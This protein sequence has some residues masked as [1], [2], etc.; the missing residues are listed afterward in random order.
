MPGNTG[1]V[2]W[3]GALQFFIRVVKAASVRCHSD[4]S[5]A[6]Y[7]INCNRTRGWEE[8]LRVMAEATPTEV[9]DIL[10]KSTLTTEDFLAMPIVTEEHKSPGIYMNHVVDPDKEGAVY[11]GSSTRSIADW[12]NQHNNL[13]ISSKPPKQRTPFH[14]LWIYS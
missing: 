8:I 3:V 2:T 6:N 1:Y 10:G 11:I 5:D 13:I 4:K 7:I 12:V 14:Y 9:Q